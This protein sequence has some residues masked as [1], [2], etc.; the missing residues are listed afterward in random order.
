[1]IR[2]MA[3]VPLLDTVH[4]EVRQHLLR[5]TSHVVLRTT[6]CVVLARS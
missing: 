6:C 5:M 1:M 4:V 2:L 3:S